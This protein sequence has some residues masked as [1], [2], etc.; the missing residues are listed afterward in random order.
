MIEKS[1]ITPTFHQKASNRSSDS[2]LDVSVIYS[3][4]SSIKQI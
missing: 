2:L 3:L 1:Q 4:I